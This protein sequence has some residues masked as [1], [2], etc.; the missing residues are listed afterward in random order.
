MFLLVLVG[1][2]LY[3]PGPAALSRVYILTLFPFKWFRFDVL[4]AFLTNVYL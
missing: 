1:C 2:W 4:T 3:P